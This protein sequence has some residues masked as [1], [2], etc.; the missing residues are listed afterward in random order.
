DHKTLA[1]QRLGRERVSSRGNIVP[2]K[3]EW[4]GCGL[5]DLIAFSEKLDLSD[6]AVFIHRVGGNRDVRSHG[7]GC[8]VSGTGD[9]DCRGGNIRT[10][11]SVKIGS[12]D[13]RS[14]VD[15]LGRSR[16]LPCHAHIVAAAPF[17]M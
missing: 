4:S 1:I 3:R 13:W 7:K 5:A 8:A 6:R 12:Q 11:I 15:G 2:S 10:Q 9:S 17:R 16:Q 14:T